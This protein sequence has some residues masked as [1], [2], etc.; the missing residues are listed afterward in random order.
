MRAKKTVAIGILGSK[1]DRVGKGSQRWN[2]WRPTL[3]LCQQPDLLID[4]LELIHGEAR[5][6]TD[7]ALKV[8]ADIADRL[9][10]AVLAVAGKPSLTEDGK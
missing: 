4:R 8:A 6:D 7:L 5:W 1:L 9:A 3:S 10:D 2:K